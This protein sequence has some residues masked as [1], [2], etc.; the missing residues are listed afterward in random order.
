M[1]PHPYIPQHPDIH[2]PWQCHMHTVGAWTVVA[3]EF[4]SRAA[5]P[6]W[7]VYALHR[8]GARVPPGPNVHEDWKAEL[9]R[10]ERV[11]R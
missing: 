9:N 7:D 8:S 3:L 11:V 2:G 1:R 10:L 4:R 6:K 5:E